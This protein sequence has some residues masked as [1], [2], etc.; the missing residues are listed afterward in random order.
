M[1]IEKSLGHRGR[2]KPVAVTLV[3]ACACVRATCELV[4]AD[5]QC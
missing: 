1:T 5:S 4:V 2:A 3:R